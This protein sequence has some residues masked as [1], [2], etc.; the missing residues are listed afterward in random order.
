MHASDISFGAKPKGFVEILMEAT[1]L[2]CVLNPKRSVLEEKD[3]SRGAG[4]RIIP[5]LFLFLAV[6]PLAPRRACEE[7]S[8]ENMGEIMAPP[9]GFSETQKVGFLFFE[10]RGRA[11]PRGAARGDFV[12]VIKGRE[13]E[14]E[15]P[16]RGILPL[17][18]VRKSAT[19]A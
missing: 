2:R 7:R 5:C 13:R 6:A 3:N 18:R 1:F 17:P 8:G 10:R 14:G 15:G 4:R 16:R 11:R 12:F 9:L 19:R